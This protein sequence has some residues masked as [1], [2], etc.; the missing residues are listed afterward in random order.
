MKE[1]PRAGE[2]LEEDIDSAAARFHEDEAGN[3]LRAVV[4]ARDARVELFR[5]AIQVLKLLLREHDLHRL[6][7]RI[8]AANPRHA[9]AYRRAT[10]GQRAHARAGGALR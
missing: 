2:N 10:L 7:R 4:H 6:A 3:L 8:G 5:S 1:A 9:R